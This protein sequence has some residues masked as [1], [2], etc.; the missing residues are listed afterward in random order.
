MRSVGGRRR[1]TAHAP[2]LGSATHA[3]CCHR[4]ATSCGLRDDLGG[5]PS[6]DLQAEVA[7]PGLA[8][9]CGNHSSRDVLGLSAQPILE[10][11]QILPAAIGLAHEPRLRPCHVDSRRRTRRPSRA[12]SPGARRSG[13]RAGRRR[14]P[15]T[16]RAS[17]R[18]D[19]RRWVCRVPPCATPGQR[20]S[21]LTHL[22]QLGHGHQA[23][24]EPPHLPSR[25][26]RETVPR[27]SS[28]PPCAPAWSAAHQLTCMWSGGVTASVELH[29]GVRPARSVIVTQGHPGSARAATARVRQAQQQPGTAMTER[30]FG[31]RP[32][33]S[34][35]QRGVL[36]A[37][38]ELR[39]RRR[40]RHTPLGPDGGPRRVPPLRSGPGA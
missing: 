3:A 11:A 9:R 21:W 24:R 27:G 23:L 4:L 32:R 13:S 37:R 22:D 38:R 35:R 14:R 15:S 29:P 31:K 16:T 33:G 36:P 34:P 26:R 25:H 8:L 17:S 40:R 18:G 20:R 10:L 2:G 39:P 1:R 30:R 28:R 19:R 6:N 12:R 7:Q 5:V